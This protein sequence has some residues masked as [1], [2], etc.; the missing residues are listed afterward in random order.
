MRGFGWRGFE[1]LG[2][3]GEEGVG[4]VVG[5]LRRGSVTVKVLVEVVV[6]RGSVGGEVLEGVA[7]WR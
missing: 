2:K 7:V 6:V 1:E 3:G 5:G 4:V